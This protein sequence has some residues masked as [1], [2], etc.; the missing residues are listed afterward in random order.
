MKPSH[1]SDSYSSHELLPSTMQLRDQNGLI[2]KWWFFIASACNR[3]RGL[4]AKADT[5]SPDISLRTI[6]DLHYCCVADI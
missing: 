5:L 2:C 4:S 6:A 1:G 3:T